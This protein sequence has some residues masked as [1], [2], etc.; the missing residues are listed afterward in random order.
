MY[1]TKIQV[2]N[3]NNTLT[4]KKIK[5]LNANEGFHCIMYTYWPEIFILELFDLS[6]HASTLAEFHISL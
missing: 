2:L 1:G 4:G 6:F 5:I 3:K